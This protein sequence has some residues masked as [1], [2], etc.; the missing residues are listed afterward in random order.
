MDNGVISEVDWITESKSNIIEHIDYIIEV[1][2]KLGILAESEE[3]L[4]RKEL[5]TLPIYRIYEI[6][7]QT[8]ETYSIHQ[9]VKRL[10]LILLEVKTKGKDFVIE[11]YLDKKT[12]SDLS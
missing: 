4:K 10:D 2:K 9:D 12:N 8:E 7:K 1:S 3:S 6:S 5:L 11:K